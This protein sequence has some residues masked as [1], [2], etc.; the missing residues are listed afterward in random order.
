MNPRTNYP[1]PITRSLPAA[2]QGV[3]ESEDNASLDNG[4]LD[5]Y[6]MGLSEAAELTKLAIE[7]S[8]CVHTCVMDMYRHLFWYP[9]GLEYWFEAQSKAYA[10]WIQFGTDSMKRLLPSTATERRRWKR[11]E[12]APTPDEIADNIE[13]MEDGLDAVVGSYD[14]EILA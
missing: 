7:T 6:N 9:F 3:A 12:P 8:F 4:L 5:L 11:R 14:D 13:R 10:Y 1:F 2:R